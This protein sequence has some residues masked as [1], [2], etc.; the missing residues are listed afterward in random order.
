MES[1]TKEPYEAPEILVVELQTS[2]CILQGSM[3]QRSPYDPV[4]D[5]P[6]NG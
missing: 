2:S 3:G 1:M 5:N 6:F 4:Y